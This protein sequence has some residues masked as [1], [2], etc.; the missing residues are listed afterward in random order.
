MINYILRRI[1]LMIPTLLG[2]TLVVFIVMAMSPGGIS[3]QSLVDGFGLKPQEKQ[4]LQDYYNQRYGLDDPAPLQYLRW[5]NNVSPIGFEQNEQGHYTA[6]SW[7]K[8]SDLGESIRYGRPVMDLVQERVPITLLLNVLSIPLI[9]SI[10]IMVGVRAATDRGGRFDVTSNVVMLGLWSVPTMLTGVLLIGLFAS[11]QYWQ[12]FPTSGLSER[13][14]VDMPFLP[15]WGS[16][17]DVVKLFV[18]LIVGA[19]AGT[20]LARL[21][22]KVLRTLLVAMTGAALLYWATAVLPEPSGVLAMVLAGLLGAVVFGAIGASD[23]M[24]LRVSFLLLVGAGVGVTLATL[25]MDGGYERGF[26]LDRVW[27]L[28]LPVLCLSYGGFA[29]LAR[30]TRS[31]VLENL[32]AD[33]ARTARAKGVPEQDVIWG[34]VFRNSLLPLITVSASLLPSLLAGSVIVESIFSIDG[35]GK[36]AVEAVKGRDKELVLSITFISGLLTLL[37]YLLADL[38][39]AVADPRV[40]YE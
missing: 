2:I 23:Y 24:A 7:T 36:L 17:M 18:L 13:E 35:M 30:L 39:Y 32:Q 19:A 21:Q 25:W 28:V 15:Y 4:A 10:A 27:H 14:A 20:L 12:W 8:G 3:A 5:L 9:Y 11:N 22:L 40:S 1:L 34:H 33:F 29:F 6:F 31:S 37:S 38:M 16:T 26:F